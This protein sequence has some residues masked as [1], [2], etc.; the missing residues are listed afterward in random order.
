MLARLPLPLNHALGALVGRL[1]FR[2]SPRYRHRLLDNVRESRVVPAA[3]TMRLARA[4]AAEIGKG[5]TE[6]AWALFRAEDAVARVTE[7]TGWETVERLRREG[8]PILFVT[9]HLGSYDIAGRYL[10]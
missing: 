6:M 1:V 10:W 2:L 3:E 5:A 8:R 7:R 4:N 9:P